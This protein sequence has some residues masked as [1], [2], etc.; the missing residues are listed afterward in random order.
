MEMGSV[1]DAQLE[2]AEW[3]PVYQTG[4][5][6]H[7]IEDAPL[8]KFQYKSEMGL[9]ITSPYQPLGHRCEEM[10]AIDVLNFF[11]R[12]GWLPPKGYCH[13]RSPTVHLPC[14]RS[15][16]DSARIRR[17]LLRRQVR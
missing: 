5:L 14:P 17:R 15:E 13:D 7:I 8:H 10:D 3:Q 11:L 9:M 6:L 12:T 4:G 2:Q 1:V 16:H